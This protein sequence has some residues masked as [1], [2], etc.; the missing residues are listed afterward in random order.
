MA[1]RHLERENEVVPDVAYLLAHHYVRYL[2]DLSGG[3]VIA[4]LVQRHYGVPDAGLHFYDFSLLGKAKVYKDAYRH[5]L[6]AVALSE[7]ERQDVLHRARQAFE[8]T[9]RVFVELADLH[10]PVPVG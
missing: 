1:S 2:G 8:R 3:Q 5:Q 6:D 4:R 9:R 7:T 10:A